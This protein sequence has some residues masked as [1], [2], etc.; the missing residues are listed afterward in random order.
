LIHQKVMCFDMEKIT[1][2]WFI[3]QVCFDNGLHSV[4]ILGSQTSVA[5]IHPREL[6]DPAP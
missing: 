2:P 1:Q 6:L 5:K 4:S 3:S